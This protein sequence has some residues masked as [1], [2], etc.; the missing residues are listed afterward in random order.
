MKV[1]K[2]ITGSLIYERA[3]THM[4]G[5]IQSVTQMKR[6]SDRER[7]AAGEERDESFG[8]LLHGLTDLQKEF[9]A[10]SERLWNMA[11]K[12][13][14]LY[15]WAL[16]DMLNAVIVTAAED[17]EIALS[18]G[19]SRGEIMMIENFASIL[20]DQIV[21]IMDK[22]RKNHGLFVKAARRNAKAIIKETRQNR[23]RDIDM[24]QNTHKCPNCGGGMYAKKE[25][26]VVRIC[27]SRCQLF[28]IVKDGDAST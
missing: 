28:E 14:E 12:K 8:V 3:W 9:S 4:S 10:E 15:D 6:E 13:S 27:C 16:R 20:G 17:Y 23:M 1:E 22:I 5:I 26:G 21:N 11:S 7:D 19:Q 25:H 18:G 2:C 24:N